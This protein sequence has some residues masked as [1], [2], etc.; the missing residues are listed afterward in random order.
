M[1]DREVWRRYRDARGAEPAG[2]CPDATAWAAW[3]DGREVGAVEAHL[4]RCGSCRGAAA[5]LRALVA[6]RRSPAVRLMWRAAAAA[7]VAAA[8]ALGFAVGRETPHGRQAV[9]AAAWEASF[10]LPEEVR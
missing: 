9:R 10:G 8:C 5:E 6:F 2:P 1:D 7:S 4:A 3:L